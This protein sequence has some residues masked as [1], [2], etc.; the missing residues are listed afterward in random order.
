MKIFNTVLINIIL[1]TFFISLGGC[2][3]LKDK[4]ENS[5]EAEASAEKLFNKGLKHNQNKNYTLAIENFETLESRYPFGPY[6]QQAQLEIAYANFKKNE[7][8]AALAA[9]DQFL[10]INP[11][12]QHIDYAYYLKGLINFNLSRT[13]LDKFTDRNAASMDALP[14]KESFSYFRQLVERFPNSRYV[15]DSKQRMVHLR[16]LLASHELEVAQFYKKRGAYSAVANRTSY[17][18][19]H[20]QEADVMP[21]ALLMLAD[22]YKQL[23]LSE[24]QKETMQVLELNFPDYRK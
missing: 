7:P 2:A 21:E 16:N 20:Y 8:D 19:E 9:I 18:V 5:E 14:L 11:R 22:A 3:V 23:G 6:A 4:P 12:H 15:E 1:V 10:K 17:V 13:F 24:A